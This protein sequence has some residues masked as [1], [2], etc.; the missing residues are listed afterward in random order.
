LKKYKFY[1]ALL[2]FII[3]FSGIFASGSGN[4]IRLN[5]I[6]FA[7]D[8]VKIASVAV[9]CTVFNV[10]SSKDNHIVF[11]GAAE[12]PMHSTDT[13]EEIYLF[14][15]SKFTL[16]G[17][18]YIYAKQAGKSCNFRIDRNVYDFAFYTVT[19]G[20][21]LWR[22]GIGVSTVHNGQ[23]FSTKPCHTQDAYLDFAGGKDIKDATGG[24]HDAGDY[25]K[26]TVNG[27]F[28]AGLMLK[29]WE[30]FGNN[31]K[32]IRLN[33]PESGGNFPDMLAEVKWE[34][35]WLLKMQADDGSV[36]HKVST[37]GFP[38][39]VMP[40]DDRL[41]RFFAP[42]SSAAT[43][44]F[45]A[46]IAETAQNLKMYDSAVSQRY[47]AAAEKSYLFLEQHP[48]NHNAN[49]INFNTGAYETADDD[50]RL[51]ASAELWNATGKEKYLKDFE[52]RAAQYKNKIDADWDW[53]NVKNLGMITYY[54]S[55]NSGKEEALV[56]DIKN[57]IIKC[58]DGIVL[59]AKNNAYAR[60]LG[61]LYYWGCNGTVARQSLVLQCANMISPDKKYTAACDDIISHLFGRNYYGRSYVTGLGYKP[62][63]HI[64]DRR[65][66]SDN[67]EPPWP[68]YLA[69]G[70][71]NA[72]EWM[73]DQDSFTTNEIAINWN[74]SLIY[75]L[76]AVLNDGP[77]FVTTM[78][79]LTNTP[80]ITTPAVVP[81]LIYDG[82]TT[83][84]RLTDVSAD[85]DATNVVEAKGGITGKA[86]RISFKKSKAEQSKFLVF[87]DPVKTGDYNYIE[88]D[89]K[90]L[91]AK[92]N[93]L[94]FGTNRFAS[95]EKLVNINDYI[96]GGISKQWEKARLPLAEMI[97]YGDKSFGELIWIAVC[98]KD[99]EIV[100]DNIKLINYTPPTPTISPSFTASPDVTATPTGTAA[101]TSSNTPVVTSTPTYTNT[102]THTTSPTITITVTG[103]PET[104]TKIIIENSSNNENH[105][106]LGG[107]WYTYDDSNDGGNSEIWP[108]PQSNFEKSQESF[109]RNGK[110]ITIKGKVTAV[111]Q[112][113]YLG[114]GT[115]FDI[116]GKTMDL[117]GCMGLRFFYKGDGKTYRVKL[118]STDGGFARGTSD[119]QYGAE[120]TTDSG[121]QL[122]EMK[123][124]S[125]TQE[126]YWGSKVLQQNALSAVRDIQ[127]QTKGQPYD[128]IELTIDR[129]EIFGC[130]QQ[131]DK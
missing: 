19:R 67:I 125:F 20:M 59:S 39:E 60:P 8:S 10:I 64:H 98:E 22:C 77:D 70:G 52:K 56:N 48:E 76:A 105:N 114:M 128:S 94:Y 72:T 37:Q 103:T 25:G 29:A 74:S 21:Y 93:G 6:G 71:H 69:G 12:G 122:F 38:G 33:L 41:Q 108:K 35:D 57:D 99:T 55:K 102:Q 15:F 131:S 126:P 109:D 80:V 2:I 95:F 97:S 45:T 111:F 68:G 117:N 47:L 61:N 9:K 100:I 130:G 36:Y 112:W 53:G 23:L 75:A 27:A 17:E 78:A 120:F 18:Y 79:V 7:P 58:A 40:Q 30:H 24:W 11:T 92:I 82:D 129:V 110:A 83:G 28:S 31:I 73:D 4:N 43:A 107:M 119:N 65:S 66:M 101:S 51:W 124:S 16:P 50:D 88:F 32:R 85:K 63:V 116:K 123:F 46:V 14:D 54:F 89:I 96:Q 81:G 1:P 13:A 26:Y 121:W 42:W 113:G 106:M 87:K 86:L 115:Q 90:T 62:P 3:I 84:Y 34:T 5:S 44:D 49:Q 91:S 104:G 118:V 127:W